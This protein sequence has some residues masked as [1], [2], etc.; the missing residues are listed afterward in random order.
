MRAV[1]GLV[2]L[3]GMGLAGFAV[4]MV[5]GYFDDQA[6]VLERERQRSATAIV[7]VDVYAP[8]RALTYGELLTADDVT[9]IKYARD[10]LPEG[11]FQTEE[12]L[13]P[14]GVERP[15][16]VTRP[17]EINEPIMAVKVTEPG[18]SRGI[19][20][21]LDRGMRAF[22]LADNITR[23]FAEEL[24]PNDRLDVYWGG[25]INGRRIT[26]LIM[27]GL[28]VIAVDEADANGSGGG[29]GVVIQVTPEQFAA[30]AS[31]QDAGSLSLTPVGTG[32][33]TVVESIQTDIQEVLGIEEVIVAEPEVIQEEQK[34]YVSQGFGVNAVQI[35][36]ECQ[37]Q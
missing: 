2:L 5:K 17:M 13:F 21:L 1:F 7:T 32:D 10:Y 8:N 36:I 37:E 29:S 9:L 15:R 12:E 11:V 35:E 26:R 33:D 28:Q 31:A 4:F 25:T 20:A 16:V 6:A 24:R 18:A 22:P 23:A 3:I 34:C 19:T 30:L 27:T 14:E